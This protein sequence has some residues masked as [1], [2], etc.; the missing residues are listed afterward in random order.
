MK[1]NHGIG[2]IAFLFVTPLVTGLSLGIAP[3]SAAIIA[4]SAAQVAIENFSHRPTDTGTSTNTNTLA[5]ANEAA[6]LSQANADAVFL[7]NCH[8]LLASNLSQ[9]QVQGDGSNYLGLAESQASILGDFSIDAKETFS[10]TF[11]TVLNL[12]TSVDNPQSER[13]SA[14]GNISF[15]LIDTVSNL[16]LDSFQ[17][18]GSLESFNLPNLS[19]SY[20][21]SFNPTKINFDF[22][23]QGSTNTLKFNTSGVYSRRF[24][25]ATNLRLV[26]VKNNIAVAKSELVSEAEAVPEPTTVLGTVMFLG[27][28][29]KRRKHQNKLSEVKSKL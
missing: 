8:Q 28:L 15:S 13:A 25:S 3:S 6:V 18:N 7:S 11:Q 27:F 17:I 9:S 23:N 16:L 12:L 21:N 1:I 2:S 14:K 26:E 29:A 4:G 24:N 5:I 22:L 19:L 10:F 20:T